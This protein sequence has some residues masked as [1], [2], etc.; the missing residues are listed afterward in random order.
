M[1][2]T[3]KEKKFYL[4]LF[5]LFLFTM[6]ILLIN[7]MTGKVTFSPV[8]LY[9]ALI[10]EPIYPYH[11]QVLWELRIPR[12][13]I[14]IL[15]G[16][17]LGLAGA[18]L[19]SVT[20]NPLA[21]PGIMGVTAGSVF[22]AVLGITL[23]PQIY[24]LSYFLPLLASLGGILVTLCVLFISARTKQNH[25]QIA[26]IGVLLSS[27]TQACTSFILLSNQEA[28]GSILLWIIG[29]LNGRGW[30]H[31]EALLP[32]AIF[33]LTLGLLSAGLANGL[34]L[35]D[36]Q[37]RSLGIDVKNARFSLLL[38]AALLTAGAVSTIGAISFIG[39]IGPHLAKQMIGED[40]RRFF[41]VSM[42]VS[43]FLLLLSDTVAQNL[44]IYLPFD[45]FS[46]ESQVPAGAITALLGAPFFIYLLRATTR[47]GIRS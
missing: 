31:F 37:A 43:S 3:A 18:I 23:I 29:S 36:A 47:K 20:R 2:T 16:A 32:V 15:A 19:Q 30:I 6:V 17:M 24:K 9:Q 39:L 10:G 21:E 22:F 45:F 42:L 33:T 8:E 27:I 34:R 25:V 12:V 38:L 1:I 35:G 7:I 14:A 4:L 11:E 40:A 41:P 13:L 28:M 26:L 44:I 46:S 5:S